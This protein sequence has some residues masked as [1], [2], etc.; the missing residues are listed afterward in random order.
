MWRKPGERETFFSLLVRDGVY[1]LSLIWGSKFE[2]LEGVGV[3]RSQR[4]THA[5]NFWENPSW[6]ET[7]FSL[8]FLY[9]FSF[10][11]TVFCIV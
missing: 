4:N 11:S 7:S 8:S 2:L 6:N 3:S 10:P 5:Q 9:L 1:T